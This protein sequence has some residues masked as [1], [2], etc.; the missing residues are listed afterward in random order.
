[1]TSFVDRKVTSSINGFSIVDKNVLLKLATGDIPKKDIPIVL[2]WS[3][4]YD[5][6]RGVLP[7]PYSLYTT[8]VFSLGIVEVYTTLVYCGIIGLNGNV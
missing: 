7:C 1:M 3:N 5:R 8:K 6:K 4:K 2:K